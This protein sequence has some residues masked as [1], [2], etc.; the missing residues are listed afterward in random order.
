MN[1]LK[2]FIPYYYYSIRPYA[3]DK[4]I[5]KRLDNFAGRYHF[6]ID[7]WTQRWII[8]NKTILKL[9][10]KMD[11]KTRLTKI[12]YELS[13]DNRLLEDYSKIIEQL[14]T[15]GI[16]FYSQSDHRQ[17]GY[18]VYNKSE[19][20]GLHLE[21]TNLCNMRC[22]HCYV[23]SG[24]KL[25]AE[26]NLEEIKRIIDMIPPFS[27]KQIAISGGEPTLH[28]DLEEILEYCTLVNGHHVDL[29]TN[30]KK[31]SER[32]INK[33]KYINENVSSKIRI[34]LSLEGARK[35]TNDRIRGNGEYANAIATLKKLYVHNL[36]KYIIIFICLT[37]NN[38][39]EIDEM[40]NLAEKY[41]VGVLALSQWQKQGRV[42]D[43]QNE[44]SLISRDEWI[45][46]SNRIQNYNNPKLK[47]HGNFYGD[48]KNNYDGH[49]SLESPLFPKHLY[50]YNLFPRVTP[51]GNVLA[52][53]MWVDPDWFLGNLKNDDL[54]KCFNSPKFYK[55]LEDMKDRIYHVEECKICEWKELCLCGSPGHTYAEYGR[56]TEKDIFCDL[57]K[58]WFNKYLEYKTPVGK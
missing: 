56:M 45:K 41:E 19:I 10:K 18:P 37:K 40:I 2:N 53:Q 52:D 44:T 6:I 29:Y 32:L 30:G 58:Y 43:S 46:L 23:D 20:Q 4:L 31:F 8:G 27:N 36:N 47:I 28:P 12:F 48:I 16:I 33:I 11:G 21:I 54:E 35:E 50:F 34:Q 14:F 57:R 55:Q 15:D 51:Q 5:F 26:L 25:S 13:S 17:S 49:F 42:F 38:I 9:L 1:K 3:F 7:P 22:K 24:K 39:E